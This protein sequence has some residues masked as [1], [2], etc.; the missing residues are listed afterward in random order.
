MLDNEQLNKADELIKQLG[1]ETAYEIATWILYRLEKQG[2]CIWQTYDL[3]DIESFMGR[4][5]TEE[6]L[7]LMQDNLRNTLEYITPEEV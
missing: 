5:P 2:L 1:E 7:E 4:K 6:E 3:E